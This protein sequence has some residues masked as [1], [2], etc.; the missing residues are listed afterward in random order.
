MFRRKLIL[1]GHGYTMGHVVKP[2]PSKKGIAGFACQNLCNLTL[3][4]PHF[5]CAHCT[6]RKVY[7]KKMNSKEPVTLYI[8]PI[9]R[10]RRH[11]ILKSFILKRLLSVCEALA[12]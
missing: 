2:T 1:D 5:S 3:N 10:R 11:L 12:R 4:R 6:V 9:Y 8:L 7:Y